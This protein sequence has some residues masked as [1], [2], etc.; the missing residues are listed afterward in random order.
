MQKSDETTKIELAGPLKPVF[1]DPKVVRENIKLFRQYQ[2]ELLD[3]E[4]D[5]EYI[6]GKPF[7]KKSGWNVLN[8]FFGV[9]TVPL[10]SWKEALP[11]GEFMM[12]VVV[13]ASG[14]GREPVA[15]SGYCSSIEMK[16]KHKGKSYS[17][18]E[19]HCHGMAET[20]AVGRASGAFYMVEDVSAEEVGDSPGFSDQ[21]AVPPN[22]KRACRCEEATKKANPKKPDGSC[23]VCNGARF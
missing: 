15:R 22:A 10:K 23:P 20:R 5:I 9:R 8:A 6:Q 11:D 14:A 7:T 17:A 13:E 18:I 19:S 1:A 21:G 4:V 2:K 3:P 16:E 12:V